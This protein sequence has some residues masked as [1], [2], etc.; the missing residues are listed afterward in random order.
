MRPSLKMEK[1]P[2]SPAPFLYLNI[3]FLLYF[4]AS[5]SPYIFRIVGPIENPHVNADNLENFSG[6]TYWCCASSTGTPALYIFIACSSMSSNVDRNIAI[7][8][9]PQSCPCFGTKIVSLSQEANVF[10][11]ERQPE[12]VA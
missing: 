6:I 12:T 7:P 9:C 10:S 2:E 8:S 5:H 1:G 3:S 4:F 11:V